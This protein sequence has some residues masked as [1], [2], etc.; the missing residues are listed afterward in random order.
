MGGFGDLNDCSE[1][2]SGQDWNHFKYSQS[3]GDEMQQTLI[4]LQIL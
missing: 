3:V 1:R 2:K 4:L